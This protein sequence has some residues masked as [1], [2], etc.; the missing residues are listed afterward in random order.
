MSNLR[1]ISKCSSKRSH[2]SELNNLIFQINFRIMRFY[3][4]GLFQM[5]PFYCSVEFYKFLSGKHH[6]E[7][8]CDTTFLLMA[9]STAAQA[10]SSLCVST[11]SK[12]MAKVLLAS[13]SRSLPHAG[14]ETSC[15]DSVLAQAMGH[16]LPPSPG[17][18]LNCGISP[19]G[20]FG[21]PLWQASLV[22]ATVTPQ[23]PSK[24]PIC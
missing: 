23:L 12:G 5:P 6:S 2:E 7:D 19:V 15:V 20:L 18:P 11:K 24:N 4:F 10:R 21:S 1:T 3:S 17:S 13:K 22:K 8:R 14:W 9:R 16:T